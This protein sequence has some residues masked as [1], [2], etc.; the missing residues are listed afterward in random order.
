MTSRQQFFLGIFI[1]FAI[2]GVAWYDTV[3][4]H[5]FTENLAF[6][7]DSI[8]ISNEILTT[9]THMGSNYVFC[10]ML[11]ILLLW[12]TVKKQYKGVMYCL[13]TAL[14]VIGSTSLMKHL[15][16]SPRP[17]PYNGEAD[18]FPSGHTVRV[19][20]WCGLYLM[21]DKFKYIKLP[22]FSGWLL[23]LIALLVGYSRLGLGRHWLSDVIA[24]YSLTIG[25]LLI[26]Y[27][28]YQ[29]QEKKF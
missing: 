1:C 11:A 15:V 7:P 6:S 14:V 9:I 21:M 27:Y 4:L 16:F 19:T 25:V 20:L 10:G 22:D 12:M 29:T 26:L 13:V 28:L 8:L 3:H 24:G 5:H 23:V 2:F 18:S 17:I